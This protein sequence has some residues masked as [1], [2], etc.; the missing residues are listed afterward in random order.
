M[1]T[2][3]WVL[4]AIA[5]IAALIWLIYKFSPGHTTYAYCQGCGYKRHECRCTKGPGSRI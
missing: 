1:K 2:T 5:V 3:D 4:I